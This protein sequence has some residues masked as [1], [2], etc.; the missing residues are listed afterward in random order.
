MKCLIEIS[1]APILSCG[2]AGSDVDNLGGGLQDFGCSRASRLMVCGF[3][4][5]SMKTNCRVLR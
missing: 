3:G 2:F 5:C 1:T 4:V